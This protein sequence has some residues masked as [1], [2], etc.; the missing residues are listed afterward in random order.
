M[1]K[2]EY[3]LKIIDDIP[4]DEI[5]ALYY[6][7]EY[8]DMCKGPHVTSMRH[9]KSFK[10]LNVSG[11]IGEVI[12]KEKMLQRIYGTAWNSDKELKIYISNLEEASKRDHRKLGQKYDLFHFQEEAPGMVFWHPKGWTIFRIL[13]DYIREKLEN[14]RIRRNKN[15]R[16]CRSKTLGKNL[17]TG[18]NIEKI[19]T[20]LK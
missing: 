1:R 9:L 12:Q 15:P 17:A 18:I 10:L 14:I 8:I 2:E 6:H 11:H 7:E 19:C 5:I 4:E 16:S 20:L 13:E 3:K